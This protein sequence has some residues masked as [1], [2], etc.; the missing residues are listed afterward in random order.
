MF[1]IETNLKS[2]SYRLIMVFRRYFETAY[3]DEIFSWYNGAISLSQNVQKKNEN[4]L[5]NKKSSGQ[6]YF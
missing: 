6:N 2:V 5:T 4:R 1:A 3:V